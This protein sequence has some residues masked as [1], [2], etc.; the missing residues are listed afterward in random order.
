MAVASLVS[1]ALC[2]IVSAILIVNARHAV[3]EEIGSAYRLAHDAVLQRLSPSHGARDVMARRG[4]KT[5]PHPIV[6]RC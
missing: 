2:L 3:E 6:F 1:I 5:M 4:P